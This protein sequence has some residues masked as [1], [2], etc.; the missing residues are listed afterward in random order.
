[1][2]NWELKTIRSFS[3]CHSE[4]SEESRPLL[5]SG[6][7]DEILRL[8]LRMTRGDYPQSYPFLN[9][10]LKL[11]IANSSF[12]ISYC[13][14]CHSLPKR[15][16]WS[17]RSFAKGEAGME[18]SR[19]LPKKYK[20]EFDHSYTLGPFPTFE[21]LLHRPEQVRAVYYQE[22][23]REKEKLL[24]LCAERRSP[25]FAGKRRWS[26]SLKR[27]SAMRRGNLRN[28]PGPC[29][30]RFPMWRWWSPPTWGTWA[31]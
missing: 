25:A 24:S 22:G 27:R 11:L 20:K 3:T 13:A 7:K 1:M 15:V 2:I 5:F 23:F 18:M 30:R 6:S 19:E 17:K 16:K 28:I 26:A 8:R 21:L 4:R 29:G 9:S 12:L 10:V 31:P 14:S